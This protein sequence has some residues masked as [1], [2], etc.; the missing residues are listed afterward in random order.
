MI[1]AQVENLSEQLCDNPEFKGMFAGH[2]E[3]LALD[4][5][6]VSLDPQYEV[7]LQRDANGEVIFVTLRRDGRMIGYFVGFVAPGLHYRTCL[8]CTM[9]IF[10]VAPE[11]RGGTAALKLFRTVEREL[12]RRGVQRWFVGS[13][14]HKDASRLFEALKFKPV[15]TYYSKWI[16]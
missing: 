15:E 7:Y 1:T 14:L 11:H 4:K 8:T 10:Y 13:K 9:D 6:H 16:G 3:E 12:R 5:E 2:Y